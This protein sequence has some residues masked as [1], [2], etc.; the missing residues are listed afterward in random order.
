MATPS[1]RSYDIAFP[2]PLP[3]WSTVQSVPAGAL[4]VGPGF[5]GDGFRT[6]AYSSIACWASASTRA[7][8]FYHRQALRQLTHCGERMQRACVAFP[9]LRFL[10]PSRSGARLSNCAWHLPRHGRSG[11][12]RQP[13]SVRLKSLVQ[14]ALPA[15]S[16]CAYEAH[17]HPHSQGPL[18]SRVGRLDLTLEYGEHPTRITRV[19]QK[20]RETPPQHAGRVP[21]DH[22]VLPVEQV[23]DFQQRRLK[24][25]VREAIA[26][27]VQISYY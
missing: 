21:L 26:G 20:R 15:S 17:M 7:W 9:K 8:H 2:R 12:S 22:K 10:P 18:V 24:V 16:C 6:I 1:S 4:S 11:S 3:V 25:L 5:A 23:L 14:P 13:E 27:N 19:V